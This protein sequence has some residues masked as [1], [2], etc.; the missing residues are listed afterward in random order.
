MNNIVIGCYS[1][2]NYW[3]ELVDA[4]RFHGGSFRCKR[5]NSTRCGFYATLQD[6]QMYHT[7][8]S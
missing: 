1:C 7:T 6:A 5:C 8:K 3:Q 2:G 4:F